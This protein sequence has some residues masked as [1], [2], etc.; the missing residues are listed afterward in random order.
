[1]LGCE[2]VESTVLPSTECILINA[3]EDEGFDLFPIS[4]AFAE[5]RSHE[6][7][8]SHPLNPRYLI[9]VGGEVVGEISLTIGMGPFGA[10]LALW[11]F[12]DERLE[13]VDSEF[14][15]LMSVFQ[16]H[17]YE[18][19]RCDDIEG[20]RSPVRIGSDIDNPV[21]ARN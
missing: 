21:R 15:L 13:V 5:D 6:A 17:G 20:Y 2:S 9:E 4:N 19:T 3:H 18:L 12:K 11:V 10:Q 16:S 14:R 7:I 8:M 1:M